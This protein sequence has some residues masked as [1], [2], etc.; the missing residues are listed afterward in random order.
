MKNLRKNKLFIFII[1]EA[2][3]KG[4]FRFLPDKLYIMFD[5]FLNKKKLLSLNNPKTYSEKIQWIKAYGDL[6]KYAKY[7]DK[8]E[9]RDYISKTI[10]EK[11]LIPL[12]GVWEKFDDIPF[13]ILPQ[14]FALKATHGTGY[15]FLCKD[16]SSLDRDVLKKTVDNW[17]K[18]NY[19]TINRERQYKLLKPKIICEKYLE[20]QS[21]QLTDY[22]FYCR[23]GK[24]KI[25]QVSSSRFS[26]HKLD[27]LDLNWNKLSIFYGYPNSNKV[28]SKPDNFQE[29]IEISKKLSK[30]FTFVRVDLYSVNKKV[31]F[32]ELTFTPGSGLAELKPLSAEYRLG[33]LI[34][35]SKYNKNKIKNNPNFFSKPIHKPH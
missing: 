24:P 8:F 33:E 23:N 27:L 4:L 15:N 1:D 20:D 5:Y 28:I 21:G 22:K 29:M 25:I 3:K 6:E 11:Y 18:Q 31:Y 16:K 9:V 34:D 13:N 19:Y 2:I 14:K 32:G 30:I 35:L 26:E 12:I 7:V 10:G 17:I